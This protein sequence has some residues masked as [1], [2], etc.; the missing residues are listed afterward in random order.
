MTTYT[1]DYP[2][3]LW[4]NFDGGPFMDKLM[5]AISTPAVWSWLYALMFYMVW[6]KCGWRGLAYFVVMLGC[7]L[8]LSD[9]I[10]GVFKHTGLLKNLWAS[11]P[12]RP[13]PMYTEELEGLVHVVKQ[14]GRYGT[15]SAH[16]ATSLSIA[17]I[18]S[19]F[20]RKGWFTA[21]MATMT[22]L[23]CYS[24]IY[25]ACH[26]PFDILLGLVLGA[27]SVV[28]VFATVFAIKIVFDKDS[29]TNSKS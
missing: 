19:I 8:A 6:R 22:I 16:A 9:M 1:F 23:V 29:F 24:R 11:F 2:L 18:S 27:C 7:A 28:I 25:L 17:L 3:F 15:V 20:V 12:A 4:L 26:F 13:R 5:L 14:A 21:L 10:A